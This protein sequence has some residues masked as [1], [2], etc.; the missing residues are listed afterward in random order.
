MGPENPI[1]AVAAALHAARLRDLPTIV[2]LDRDWD[3]H[4]EWFSALTPQQRARIHDK[5]RAS[6]EAQGPT[7]E[8]RRRPTE[9]ECLVTVFPQ[10][11]G[12][13][14]L[15]YG[16]IGGS[17][18][19]TAY[20]IVV[21]AP[22]VG[23]RAIYFGASGR[24]AYLVPIG[25]DH[26]EVFLRAVAERSLPSVRDA[27]SFGWK[28]TVGDGHAGRVDLTGEQVRQLAQFAGFDAAGPAG[29]ALY[30]VE[31]LDAGPRGAGVFV[32][33]ADQPRDAGLHLDGRAKARPET[34]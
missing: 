10:L 25:G 32:S 1:A 26:E 11:W 2:Y 16:G 6:G 24:L 30:V 14:A 4:R 27:A 33:R 17:A 22:V 29:V 15:G 5:E 20:T 8:R 21:E 28:P 7:V 9:Q 34:E 31:S 18:M 23:Q 13:T 3:R 19:T 12:S